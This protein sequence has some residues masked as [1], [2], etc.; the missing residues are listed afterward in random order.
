MTR[1]TEQQRCQWVPRSGSGSSPVT[2]PGTRTG[3]GTGTR[4]LLRAL[5][6]LLLHFR[7]P[8][9]HLLP[10]LGDLLLLFGGQ[11]IEDLR[12]HLRLREGELGFRVAD[13][14][15]Q[16]LQI[17]GVARQHGVI[18]RFTRGARALG[19]RPN[20]IGVIARESPSP[21]RAARR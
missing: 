12:L 7:A 14:D 2:E 16:R 15:A 6:P 20:A 5:L 13:L 21:A 8:C 1:R 4:N 11:H 10:P 3:T 18:E 19:E 9:L 17:A